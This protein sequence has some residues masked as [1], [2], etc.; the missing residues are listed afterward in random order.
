M[1]FKFTD[2]RA[3]DSGNLSEGAKEEEDI[4]LTKYNNY[5]Y[6]Y[7]CEGWRQLTSERLHNLYTSL[8]ITK[9]IKLRKMR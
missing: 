1:P 4:Q 7:C 8:N 5:V 3:S 9:V 6:F 2:T